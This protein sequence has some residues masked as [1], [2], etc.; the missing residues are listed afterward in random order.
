MGIKVHENVFAV[1]II[2]AFLSV[3]KVHIAI[4]FLLFKRSLS[5][6]RHFTGYVTAPWDLIFFFRALALP[7]LCLFFLSAYFREVLQESKINVFFSLLHCYFD[8]TL[9]SFLDGSVYALLKPGYSPGINDLFVSLDLMSPVLS[10]LKEC[11][12]GNSH[13]QKRLRKTQ[14]IT[15]GALSEEKP[16]GVGETVRPP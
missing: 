4:A 9:S 12:F 14:S 10:L 8:I 13:Y 11:R 1:N 16:M 7:S 5:N 6:P 15:I 2:F 3:F